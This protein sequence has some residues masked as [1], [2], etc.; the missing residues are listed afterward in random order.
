MREILAKMPE[1]L[2]CFSFRLGL[3]ESARLLHALSEELFL[4]GSRM[5]GSA[6]DSVFTISDGKKRRETRV[7][8]HVPPEHRF[9]KEK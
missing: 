3:G 7:E 9:L 1:E 8:K 2:L 5:V 6:G 4:A